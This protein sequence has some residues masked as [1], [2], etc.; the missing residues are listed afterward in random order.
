MELCVFS[1]VP[2]L[3]GWSSDKKYQLTTKDGTKYLLRVSSPGKLEIQSTL[4][5][6]LQQLAQQNIPICCPV[7]LG[8]CR[9][10]VYTLY[11]WVNGRDAEDIIPSLTGQQ[12]Y[13]LGYTAGKILRDIHSIPAPETQENWSSRF[14]RKVDAK[15]QKY[16]ECPVHF[17]GDRFIIE[18]I[19]NNRALLQNRPQ[20]FQ[21]GDY[22]IGNMML[23]HGRL[24]IID[25]DSFDYGDPWEEFNRIVWCAQCSPHFASGQLDGYFD[26]RPPEK[27]FKLLAFYIASNTLSSV[28]WAI[29]FGKGEVNTMI[30]QSQDVLAWY[31]NMQTYVPSWYL[32]AAHGN[33]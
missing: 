16:R 31:S 20:C 21:H 7:K 6:I 14:N 2:I 29:P 10:G 1:I 26:G 28:P 13:D 30:N 19:E 18:Y 12:Q 9:E 32:S 15:L 33:L 17:P 27:F 22:H 24:V 3:K 5:H 23:E 25:F 4:F 11:T 8:S